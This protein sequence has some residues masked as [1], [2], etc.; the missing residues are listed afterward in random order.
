MKSQSLSKVKPSR[1]CGIDLLRVLS[2][3]MVCM[4]HVLGWG[5]VLNAT[6]NRSNDIAWF[7][8][9]AAYCAV[10]CFGLISGYVGC[11]SS[12][13]PR[14][15]FRLWLQ[16]VYYNFGITLVFLFILP[17][18]VGLKEIVKSFFP[19]SSN[20]YPFAYWYL[21][22]YALMFFF[23]P[24]MTFLLRNQPKEVLCRFIWI[25]FVLFSVLE[26]I[27]FLR[28]I[29]SPVQFG[30]SALWLAYLYMLGGF[31]RLYG[32]KELLPDNRTIRK[33]YYRFNRQSTPFY[34][35]I[36]CVTITFI[37][38]K[39]GHSVLIQILGRAPSFKSL[40]S[41]NSPTILFSAVALLLFFSKLNITRFTQ[42]FY[43][44]GQ[45]A[46]SVYLIQNQTYIWQ[47]L[48]KGAFKWV[49]DLPIWLLPLTLLLIPLSIHIVCS[50]L[51]YIRL[52][53]FK[54]LRLN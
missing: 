5:G 45:L 27:P 10:N 30:F 52:C 50:L 31:I 44:A 48:F 19:I 12:F 38:Y 26:T 29:A 42:F 2:M 46:F 16:A 23:I 21:K 11:M 17:D 15:L 33:L 9:I 36:A 8:E 37:L 47:F 43:L 24:Q 25:F 13:K 22:A 40:V 6:T 41:Y 34:V 4:L 7:F 54:I 51:D 1:N 14:N 18:S 32:I 3:Y 53:L 28:Q 49:A 20:P 35:Y 39:Y